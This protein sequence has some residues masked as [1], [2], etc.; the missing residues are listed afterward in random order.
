MRVD[1]GQLALCRQWGSCWGQDSQS[2]CFDEGPDHDVFWCTKSSRRHRNLWDDDCLSWLT[3]LPPIFAREGSQVGP[4]ALRFSSFVTKLDT[5]IIWPYTKGRM[6]EPSACRSKLS[7][8]QPALSKCGCTLVTDNF[9]TSVEL[10]NKL[11]QSRTYLVGTVRSNRKRLP[12]EDV[13]G[14]WGH[15]IRRPCLYT[16]KHFCQSN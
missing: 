14:P 1:A 4:M 9:Y 12:R 2:K 15:W 13:C 8:S 10:A 3:A 6:T 7:E 16:S 5:L 11:L